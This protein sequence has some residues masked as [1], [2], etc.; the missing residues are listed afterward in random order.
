MDKI[1]L[2]NLLKNSGIENVKI[3]KNFVYFTDPNCI[4]PAF[5]KL[6][7]YAWIAAM[8]FVIFILFG[9]A[10]LYIKNGVKISSFFSNIKTLFLVLMV[11]ALVKPSVDF[12]YG[13]NLFA[14]QCDIQKVSLSAV[15]EL[16]EQR[17]KNFA[18]SDEAMLYETFDVID[19][20]ID[21]TDTEEEY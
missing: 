17:N 15:N 19:T 14:S 7:Y 18:K 13:K 11:F 9:W 2:L 1:T 10:V 5:D 12:I 16:L 21:I 8:V 3:D 20:G 4:F 6:F